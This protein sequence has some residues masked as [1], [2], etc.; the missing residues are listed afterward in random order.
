MF[1]EFLIVADSKWRFQVTLQMLRSERSEDLAGVENLLKSLLTSSSKQ[2]CES[3]RR[4]HFCL[5]S[6]DLYLDLCAY[7]I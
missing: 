2:V 4:G 3:L 6:A 7:S 5:C 1:S